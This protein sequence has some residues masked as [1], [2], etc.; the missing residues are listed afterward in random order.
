MSFNRPV[1]KKKYLAQRLCS[2]KIMSDSSH[3]LIEK[4]LA[5]VFMLCRSHVWQYPSSEEIKLHRIHIIHSS[6][7]FLP[8]R[9]LKN[10][11]L[12]FRLACVYHSTKK[13]LHRN[14]C[15][16]F[17][18]HGHTAYEKPRDSVNWLDIRRSIFLEKKTRVRFP[19][20]RFLDEFERV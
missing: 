11:R 2:G 4:S 13:W 14:K 1:S 15:M 18:F 3:V 8:N 17:F 10:S 5:I 20:I 12:H 16:H 6:H 19:L 7:H 9:Y